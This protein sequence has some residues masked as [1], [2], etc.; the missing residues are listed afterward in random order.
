MNRYKK[1]LKNKKGKSR[2]KNE[3]K[4]KGKKRME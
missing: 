1:M 2:Q 4:K 3:Q